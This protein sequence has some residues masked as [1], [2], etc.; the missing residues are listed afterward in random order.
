MDIEYSLQSYLVY[1]LATEILSCYLSIIGEGKALWG[2][3]NEPT[4]SI[5]HHSYNITF[6]S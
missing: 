4:C 3:P 2:E 6:T 1:L 5:Q